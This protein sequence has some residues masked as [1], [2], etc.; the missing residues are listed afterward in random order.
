MLTMYHVTCRCAWGKRRGVLSTHSHV[1]GLWLGSQLCKRNRKAFGG[2]FWPGVHPK[3]SRRA[4]GAKPLEVA[5]RATYES[6]LIYGPPVS[7]P[8]GETLEFQHLDKLV[9][10]AGRVYMRCLFEKA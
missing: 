7:L 8:W 4:L 9:F 5:Q 10:K 1:N 2:R 6:A 3:M